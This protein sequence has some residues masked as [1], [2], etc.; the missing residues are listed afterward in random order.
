MTDT[1]L[2]SNDNNTRKCWETVLFVTECFTTLMFCAALLILKESQYGRYAIFGASGAEDPL[3]M[4]LPE[5][6]YYS[7]WVPIMLP[8]ATLLKFALDYSV[9]TMAK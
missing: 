9:S 5:W 8:C 3:P 6:L 2:H 1:K 4:S 7:K